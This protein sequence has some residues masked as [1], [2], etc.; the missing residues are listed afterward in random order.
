[1]ANDPKTNGGGEEQLG[2]TPAPAPPPA[3]PARGRQQRYEYPGSNEVT[4]E[5][6]TE[7]LGPVFFGPMGE[8]LRSRYRRAVLQKD[9]HIELTSMLPEEIPGIQITVNISEKRITVVDP[10]SLPENHH[11]LDAITAAQKSLKENAPPAGYHTWLPKENCTNSEIKTW[12]FEIRKLLDA[13]YFNSKPWRDNPVRKRGG[14]MA[15][16]IGGG[17]IATRQEIEKLPGEREKEFFSNSHASIQARNKRK[18]K[19]EA[20]AAAAA[21]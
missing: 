7:R 11:I 5:I 18:E 17:K 20:E 8:A 13:P 10:L 1:M 16:I 12:L 6:V 9:E 2:T 3:T 14:P 21:S 4:I 15:V 19:Q